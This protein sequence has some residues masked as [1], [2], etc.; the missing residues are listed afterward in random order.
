MLSY[1]PVKKLGIFFVPVD[2]LS[3]SNVSEISKVCIEKK[4]EPVQFPYDHIIDGKLDESKLDETFAEIKAA[5]ID[6]VYLPS[7]NFLNAKSKEVC[8]AATRHKVLTFIVSD[9]ML[10][11]TAAPLMGLIAHRINIG[12]FSGV[13]AEE[14][15]IGKKDPKEIPYERFEKF[16]FFIMKNIM[17]SIGVYPPLMTLNRASFTE[18]GSQ[19][20]AKEKEDNKKDD[21][22]DKK[23]KKD[24]KDDVK[25]KDV[26]E[27]KEESKESGK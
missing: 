10:R 11:G 7:S 19:E 20:K 4:I 27:K 21:T 12:R 16:S 5:G 1:L 2:I 26:D 23:D 3:P 25:A 22:K 6:M 9:G 18:P 24:K 8:E 15:L 13:K 17:L 14:I